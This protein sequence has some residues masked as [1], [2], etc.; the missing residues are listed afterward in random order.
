M[1]LFPY[2]SGH[3]LVVPYR[4][5]ADLEQLTEHETAELWSMVTTATGVIRV[6][7]N[8]D[9]INIGLNLGRPAGGSIPE[10]LHVHVVPRWTGDTNFMSAVA[11]TQTLPESLDATAAKIRGAWAQ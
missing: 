6:A 3:L 4:E 2:T 8:P 9:G 11:N 5:V 7:F 10:H 1:N